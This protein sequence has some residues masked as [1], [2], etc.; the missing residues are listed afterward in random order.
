MFQCC[1]DDGGVLSYFSVYSVTYKYK[2]KMNKS[3][4]LGFVYNT[5]QQGRQKERLIRAEAMGMGESG[6]GSEMKKKKI[7]ISIY[8]RQNNFLFR[9]FVAG[10]LFIKT[11]KERIF[12]F[13]TQFCNFFFIFPERQW[14]PEKF[15]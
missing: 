9:H 4:A 5:H 6:S 14:Q 15:V 12:P 13:V 8:L 1:L 7:Y 2:N 11:K 3:R 10:L